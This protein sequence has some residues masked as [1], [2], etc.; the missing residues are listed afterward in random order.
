[1]SMLYNLDDP[2]EV[3]VDPLSPESRGVA[4]MP[5]GVDEAIDQFVGG[6]WVAKSRGRFRFPASVRHHEMVRSM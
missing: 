3:D 4:P 2:S 1:M 5:E 6:K